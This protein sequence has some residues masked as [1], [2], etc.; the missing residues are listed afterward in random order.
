MESL[1]QPPPFAV[2]GRA[3]DSAAAAFGIEVV[4]CSDRET[5]LDFGVSAAGNDDAGLMLARICLS[6]LGQVAQ[7]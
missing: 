3:I 7:G 2:C 5:I 1:N 6:D 4:V